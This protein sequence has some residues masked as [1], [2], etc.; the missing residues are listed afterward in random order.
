[1]GTK[2][3]AAVEQ[4]QA[5]R[6]SQLEAC[7]GLRQVVRSWSIDT[8]WEVNLVLMKE[9]FESKWRHGRVMFEHRVQSDDS[10]FGLGK[11][12]TDALRLG[13]SV[14]YTAGAEHLECFECNDMAK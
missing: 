5:R 2:F 9:R 8:D 3:A 14:R 13:D 7:H 1:M 6:A 12:F 4:K 10:H 11:L